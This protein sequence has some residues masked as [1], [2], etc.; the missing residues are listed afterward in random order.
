MSRLV[1]TL[2]LPAKTLSG[3]VRAGYEKAADIRSVD[4]ATLAEDLNIAPESA[5]ALLRE[6][7]PSITLVHTLA[8]LLAAPAVRTGSLPIDR[9]LGVDFVPAEEQDDVQLLNV[10]GPPGCGREVVA[11]CVTRRILETHNAEVLIIDC[12][13]H[14]SSIAVAGRFPDDSDRQ[15]IHIVSTSTPLK[16]QVFLAGLESYLD[17]N[18]K[19]KL[20][21]LSSVFGPPVLRPAARQ[22]VSRVLRELCKR[23]L[24]AI[25]ITSMVQTHFP[26]GGTAS[27][28][29]QP[30]VL[31]PQLR[32]WLP[33]CAY[34]IMLV[35]DSRN[36]GWVCRLPPITYKLIPRAAGM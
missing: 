9:L 11:L 20:V 19:I 7:A 32:D 1:S 5:L 21:V 16:L 8:E 29:R 6:V 23:R 10:C 33:P 3:L 4:S 12:H 27:S 36:T 22:L 13:G 35:P 31:R 26:D 30:A 24:V 2:S 17:A 28:S 34:E 15:R 25:I 14:L 18:L